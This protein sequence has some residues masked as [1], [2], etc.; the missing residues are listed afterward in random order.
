MKLSPLNRRA[1]YL[2]D[3]VGSLALG[4]GLAAFAVPLAAAAGSA[5]SEGVVLAIGLGLLPWAALNAWI[6]LRAVYPEGAARFNVAGDALW[7]I[8]SLA[9]LALAG[10]GLTP[11]GTIVV[12]VLAAAVAVIGVVKA[13]GLRRAPVAT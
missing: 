10:P 8:G 4:L 2:A 9:L 13:S 1:V 6:G 12:G 11:T 5:M 3:A 7:V